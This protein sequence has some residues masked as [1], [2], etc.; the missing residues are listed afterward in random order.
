MTQNRAGNEGW[1]AS[2]R[3]AD[4]MNLLTDCIRA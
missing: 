3:K 4:G 1:Q 2:T